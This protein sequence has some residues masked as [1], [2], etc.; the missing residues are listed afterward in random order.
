M[1]YCLILI[2][3]LIIIGFCIRKRVQEN[4]TTTIQD[5]VGTWRGITDKG[6]SLK[7]VINQEGNVILNDGQFSGTIDNEGLITFYNSCYTN[8]LSCGGFLTVSGCSDVT[9]L[10]KDEEVIPPPIDYPPVVPPDRRA[11]V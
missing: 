3:L 7:Y 2:S 10:E 4:Y 1:N 9:K 6:A 8:T 5:Y 11:H